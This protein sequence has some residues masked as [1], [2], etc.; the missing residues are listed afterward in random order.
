MSC[1]TLTISGNHQILFVSEPTL[2]EHP[3]TLHLKRLSSGGKGFTCKQGL[4]IYLIVRSEG[5]DS[6][7]KCRLERVFKF[8]PIYVYRQ[9]LSIQR[10]GDFHI[11]SF[12]IRIDTIRRGLVFQLQSSSTNISTTAPAPSLLKAFCI[13]N[14]WLMLVSQN[15]LQSESEA[16]F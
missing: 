2:N 9:M 16:S 11:R 6:F 14:G 5:Y 4:N 8:L 7:L 12:T 10:N 3:A 1:W 13:S 15:C